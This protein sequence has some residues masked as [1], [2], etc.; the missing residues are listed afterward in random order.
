MPE[1]ERD[2][3][4]KRRYERWR[5]MAVP[6][7]YK[8]AKSNRIAEIIKDTGGLP[9]TA[10]E[11]GVGPGGIAGPMSRQ[12]MHVFGMD[13]SVDALFRAKE[14]CRDDKVSLLL[15]NGFALPFADRTFP[16]VYASQVLHLFDHDGRLS[17]MR[18]AHRVL[19]PNGRFVFDMKNA[20]TH[21]FRYMR[22]SAE[23]KQRNF[24]PLGELSALLRQAGFTDVEMRPGLL[25]GF[26][27]ARVPNLSL[28]NTI[29]HT[30]FFVARKS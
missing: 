8:R 3:Y 25:P 26:S 28:F 11:L 6:F 9:V 15:G 14:Y 12:G 10:L 1:A 27:T 20:V 22:S 18:E 21:V 29:A 17:L 4:I 30:V 5:L 23:R 2:E 7:D 24:P 19:K 13:L 16:L